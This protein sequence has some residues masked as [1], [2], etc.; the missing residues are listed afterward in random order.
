V[1]AYKTADGPAI[2]RLRDHTDRLFRSAHIF[3]MKIPFGRDEI[4]AA[5]DFDFAVT[6]A[7]PEHS[8]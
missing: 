1:R 4:D 5:Q 2:F 6:G 3:G 8:Q 7:Q